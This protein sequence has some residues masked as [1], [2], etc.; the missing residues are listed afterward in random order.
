M[1]ANL[2]GKSQRERVRS[3]RTCWEKTSIEMDSIKYVLVAYHNGDS[4]K[5][6]VQTF[7][8]VAA[9]FKEAK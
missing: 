4:R 2:M 1:K 7:G 6:M 5:S 9:K 3:E 8:T